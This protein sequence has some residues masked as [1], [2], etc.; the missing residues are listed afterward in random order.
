MMKFSRLLE[1]GCNVDGDIW[2]HDRA[3]AESFS[4]E[5]SLVYSY[6]LQNHIDLDQKSLSSSE[7][8][9]KLEKK[10]YV[11]N[12]FWSRKLLYINNSL[13]IFVSWECVIFN[14]AYD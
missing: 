5:F 8:D 1:E 4:T 12:I 11:K 7:L 9:P 10:L 2:S 13:A 6:Y 14:S 3:T